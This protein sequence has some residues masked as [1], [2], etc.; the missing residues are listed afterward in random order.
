[1]SLAGDGR[2]HDSPAT[3]ARHAEPD[4]TDRAGGQAARKPP[5]VQPAVVTPVDARARSHLRLEVIEPR[6]HPHLPGGGVYRRRVLRVP[7]QVDGTG[8]VAQIED[9]LPTPAG[10]RGEK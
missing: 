2:V 1:R 7:G 3:P 4:A 10:I 8:R 5:P 9:V 6:M